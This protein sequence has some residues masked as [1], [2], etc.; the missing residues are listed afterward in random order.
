MKKVNQDVLEV[1]S[2]G[3]IEGNL[4]KMTCGQLDRKMYMA[5][6]EV[7]DNIGGKWNRKLKGHIF[8][9]DPTEKIEQVLL[10]GET[11]NEKKLFQ[12]F[13][14]PKKLAIKM[15]DLAEFDSGMRILE[16]SAGHGAIAENIISE[17]LV[18][19][20]L[21]TEKV[22]VL[23]KKGFYVLCED[24]L[25]HNAEYDRIIMNPPFIKQQ[26]IDHVLHAYDL[27]DKCGKIISIMSTGFTFRQNK[28]S[29]EFRNL[30]NKCGYYEH[31][32][33]GTFKDTGTM[34][35]TVLVVLKKA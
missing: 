18:C 25:N 9:C 5:V 13:E 26:D 21:D 16:P 6:N 27:L 29:V 31:L 7:L 20:E 4:F 32:D 28:K 30:V 17:N 24:F 22:L 14:T 35:K 33:S 1:L 12:F 23:K 34:I 10:T 2:R 11:V 3:E 8:P 15:I 19:L